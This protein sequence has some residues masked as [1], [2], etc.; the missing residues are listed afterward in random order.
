[1]NKTNTMANAILNKLGRLFSESDWNPIE[2]TM[3]ST[4]LKIKLTPCFDDY[5]RKDPRDIE[6]CACILSSGEQDAVWYAG[7][8]AEVAE[9]L[10]NHDTLHKEWFAQ[11]EDLK[12]YYKSTNNAADKDSYAIFADWYQDLFG[13]KPWGGEPQDWF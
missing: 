1:M 8:P 2:I 13:V 12:E 6:H 7:P 4:G 10:A 9:K 5:M 3:K 11:V